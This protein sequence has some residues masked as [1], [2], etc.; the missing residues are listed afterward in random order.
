[1]RH[2]PVPMSP[3]LIYPDSTLAET[4]THTHTHTHAHTLTHTL[5]HAPTHS[6]TLSHTQH[7]HLH[8]LTLAQEPLVVFVDAEPCSPIE[9]P[10]TESRVVCALRQ[11][12]GQRRAVLVVADGVTGA[13]LNALGYAAPEM[14]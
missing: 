3:H 2:V 12:T 7:T 13:P 11:G 4:L 6:H 10:A 8:P 14:T 1:M 5:T 9:R